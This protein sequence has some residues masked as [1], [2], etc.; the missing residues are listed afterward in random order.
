MQLLQKKLATEILDPQTLESFVAGRLIALNKAP[1]E[2]E[3]QVRPIGVGEVLRRIVGKMISWTLSEEIQ[4]AGGPLQVSTG[5]EGGS[6]AAIHAMK[7]LFDDEGSDGVILVDAAN[8]F[9]CLNRRA[10]L[11]NIQYLCPPFAVVLINIYRLPARLFLSG[12]GE[13]SSEEGTTQGCALAMSFY[14]IGT[15]P[16]IITLQIDISEVKQVWLADDAAGVGRLI[17]C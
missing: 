1:G 10:A 12:G 3:I 4:E 16:I 15:K 17:S 9:N 8:A 11:H 13:I 6:E 7:K 2:A 5:L 14:G